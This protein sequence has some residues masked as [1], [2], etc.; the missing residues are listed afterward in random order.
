MTAVVSAETFA[1]IAAALGSRS[2]DATIHDVKR[3]VIDGFVRVDRRLDVQVTEYFR[4][5]FVPD[6]VLRWNDNVDRPERWVFLRSKV[7]PSYLTEDIGLVARDQPIIF[8]LVPTPTGKDAAAVRERSHATG[9]LVTDPA[10]I[11]ELASSVDRAPIPEMVSRLIIRGGRG[12][13]DQQTTAET[14]DDINRGFDGAFNTDPEP[15]F[16]AAAVIRDHLG[17]NTAGR[18]LRLLHAIWVGS[19]G[20]SDQFP[21]APTVDGPLSDDALELLITGK[22]IDNVDFW[23]RLGKF[24]LTQLGRLEVGDRPNNLRRLLLAHADEIEGRWCRV[25]ADQARTG[26]DGQLQWG[27][28]GGAVALHGSTFTAH[29]AVD[30]IGLAGVEPSEASGI[31][32]ETVTARAATAEADISNVTVKGEGLIVGV[33]SET[34]ANI[35][36][37]PRA[38]GTVEAAAGSVTRATATLKNRH[39]VS[40]DFLATTATS[41]TKS[42]LTLRELVRHGLPL[43]WDLHQDEIA[44]LTA[45]LTPVTPPASKA[46]DQPSLFDSWSEGSGDDEADEPSDKSTED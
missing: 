31:R 17:T 24:T 39:I 5:T 9:T 4:H 45:M 26:S 42:T 33:A 23:E 29:L 8:G 13:Y 12:V 38:S 25:R 44:A 10:G 43:V 3:A 46:D 21:D 40:C 11:E 6:L 16:T 19:G 27:I 20:R 15:T 7:S 41:R 37:N 34:N 2:R 35:L 22:D 28:E 36:D 32:I 14:T 30:K 1:R 18:L